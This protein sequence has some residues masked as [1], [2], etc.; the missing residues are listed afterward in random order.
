MRNRRNMVLWLLA[1]RRRGR[2]RHPV[3]DHSGFTQPRLS[4]FA[5]P[6]HRS[7]FAA[8]AF[9]NYMRVVRPIR[10]N[11]LAS[12]WQPLRHWNP[13]AASGDAHVVD[14]DVVRRDVKPVPNRLIAVA[15][16]SRDGVEFDR[17]RPRVDGRL[18]RHR[19][20]GCRRRLSRALRVVSVHS[21]P[22]LILHVLTSSAPAVLAARREFPRPP[23]SARTRRKASGGWQ[24]PRPP[25]PAPHR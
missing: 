6:I 8:I 19:T 7:P 3:G 2:Q 17:Q 4:S 13:S 16:S 22:L 21:S 25:P 23:R 24:S 18:V 9:R 1:V 11:P 5:V 14:R 20:N 12:V 15:S 10:Q